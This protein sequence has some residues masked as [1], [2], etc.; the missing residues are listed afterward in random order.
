MPM[1]AD[2]SDHPGCRRIFC[3]PACHISKVIRQTLRFIKEVIAEN[4]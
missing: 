1:N 3:N 4:V 2:L